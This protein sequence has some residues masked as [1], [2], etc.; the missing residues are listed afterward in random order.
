[1]CSPGIA[2][3]R[4]MHGVHALGREIA[5]HAGGAAE[6]NLRLRDDVGGVVETL[7]RLGELD[8]DAKG[9]LGDG[10]V[11]HAVPHEDGDDERGQLEDDVVEDE[12]AEAGDHGWSPCSPAR[13]G[14]GSSRSSPWDGRLSTELEVGKGCDGAAARSA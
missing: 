2:L 12:M 6:A 14:S 13:S 1:M 4:S 10:I 7:G 11:R 8:R 9:D 3:R 5:Q